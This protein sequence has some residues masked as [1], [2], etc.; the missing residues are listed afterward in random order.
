MKKLILAIT[1]AIFF[2][3]CQNQE[4]TNIAQENTPKQ[5]KVGEEIT[6]NSV[7][8][9]NITIVRTQN[10][11]KLKDSNKIIM[12]D[13]FGTFCEPCR[14]EASNLMDYQLKNSN[15]MMMIGLI[16]FEN[17]TN[18]EIIENFSK[19]YNAYYFITN[20][21][22]NADIVEQILKDIDYKDALQIPF[23]VVLKDG[24][25]QKLSDNLRK[26]STEMKNFYLGYVTVP[27]LQN[28]LE[29]IKNASN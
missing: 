18:K 19:K 7:F 20:S 29:R 8:D 5:I 1:L 17:I 4:S 21:D 12:F 27:L 6:L 26:N 16:H 9:S 23:K 28:D 10:G 2:I 15:D 13:I 25:Y 14:A 11:F 24:K 3:G 22:R